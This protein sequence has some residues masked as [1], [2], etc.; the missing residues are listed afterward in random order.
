MI[1]CHIRAPLQI[2]SWIEIFLVFSLQVG[3]QSDLM[4]VVFYVSEIPPKGIKIVT[5]SIHYYKDRALNFALW[6]FGLNRIHI[7]YLNGSIFNYHVSISSRCG[8]NAQL[9]MLIRVQDLRK[10]VSIILE[11]SLSW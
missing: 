2:S 9:N 3:S 1:D 10:Y 7:A 6:K 4:I 11:H 5:L 8:S